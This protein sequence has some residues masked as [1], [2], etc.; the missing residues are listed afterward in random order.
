MW[1]IDLDQIGPRASVGTPDQD[2]VFSWFLGPHGIDLLSLDGITVKGP[3]VLHGSGT[4]GLEEGERVFLRQADGEGR[5]E[6]EVHGCFPG[7]FE[8]DLAELRF[9][10]AAF[11]FQDIEVGPPFEE[12]VIVSVV[13]KPFSQGKLNKPCTLTTAADPGGPVDADVPGGC[14]GRI[15]EPELTA[16]GADG[17]TADAAPFIGFGPE[18]DVEDG[19]TAGKVVRVRVDTIVGTGVGPIDKEGHVTGNITDLLYRSV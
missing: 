14:D 13:I 5:R 4:G 2:L 18:L 17:L 8:F 6:V 3:V 11:G 19:I 12:E 15:D 16:I 10:E 7:G 1:E 9:E